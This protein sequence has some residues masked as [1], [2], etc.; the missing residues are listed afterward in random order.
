MS[1]ISEKNLIKLKE[2]YKSEIKSIDIKINNSNQ[3]NFID[4][5]N[6]Y[7]PKRL[8]ETLGLEEISLIKSIFTNEKAMQTIQ[9]LII[10]SSFYY[11]DKFYYAKQLNKFLNSWTESLYNKPEFKQIN[12]L[13]LYL[14]RSTLSFIVKYARKFLILYNRKY[15]LYFPKAIS[16]KEA[17]LLNINY[18]IKI[19]R[20]KKEIYITSS[21]KTIS[22]LVIPSSIDKIPV[23]G[24]DD[25]S[26]ANR[27]DISRVILPRTLN[28]IG[29][30]AFFQCKN[31]SRIYFLNNHTAKNI[32]TIAEDAFLGC[33]KMFVSNASQLVKISE[34]TKNEEYYSTDSIITTGYT[35]GK[36]YAVRSL[37]SYSTKEFRTAYEIEKVFKVGLSTFFTTTF[38]TVLIYFF[39]LTFQSFAIISFITGLM[40][41]FF[42]FILLVFNFGFRSGGF[43]Q[44]K[45]LL[46]IHLIFSISSFLI[47]VF[48]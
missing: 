5:N 18:S 19:N 45:K 40:A 44:P 30:R 10:F 3:L 13:K 46:I 32:I 35:N 23:K 25:D 15:P 42:S 6:G 24:I 27:S 41:I 9:E 31:L 29:N 37:N 22:N 1:K 36:N 39:R 14:I 4:L 20:G 8:S 7:Y 26:F 2:F 17:E 12:H 34:Y 21:P 43:I 33:E 47:I 16:N 11:R 48:G 38:L 28:H